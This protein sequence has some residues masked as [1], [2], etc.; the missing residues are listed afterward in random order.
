MGRK[1]NAIHW[2][3]LRC[4]SH[5]PRHFHDFDLCGSPED[6]VK[7]AYAAWNQAFGKDDA[8]A[9][10]AFYAPDALFLP[11]T[12][13]GWR[14]EVLQRTVQDG[15]DRAQAGANRGARRRKRDIRRREVVGQW[16][17]RQRQGPTMGAASQRTSSSASRA[18]RL[19][20]SCIRSIDARRRLAGLTQIDGCL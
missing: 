13:A 20:S 1:S 11:V 6:D 15:R 7:A 9:I 5:A 16:Q 4:H 3:F 8:R 17:G 14:R 2:Y 10:A 18:G 12:H 19:K